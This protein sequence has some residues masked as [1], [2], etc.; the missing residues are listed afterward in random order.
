MALPSSGNI[1]LT[2]IETEFGAP[3]G[4]ALSEFVRG[5]AYVPDTAVN[6]AIPTSTPISMRDFEGASANTL[7]YT[8]E[9][10][11]DPETLVVTAGTEADVV[12]AVTLGEGLAAILVVTRTT[13]AAAVLLYSYSHGTLVKEDDLVLTST[14]DPTG[15]NYDTASIS[16]DKTNDIIFVTAIDAGG[17][18]GLRDQL[19]TWS[20]SYTSTTLTQ[21]DDHLYNHAVGDSTN[22]L[23]C[24]CVGNTGTDSYFIV[25]SM[26][27]NAFSSEYG[28]DSIL[29]SVNQSTG[30]ITQRDRS[31]RDITGATA[32][33]RAAVVAYDEDAWV[34]VCSDTTDA[35]YYDQ[36]R[37]TNT[38]SDD[39]NGSS[40]E[41][42]RSGRGRT[43]SAN[44]S[45]T[46]PTTAS[47]WKR[48][49]ILQEDDTTD[50]QLNVWS[51]ATSGLGTEGWTNAFD[52]V[53][54]A[55]ASFS[56][57]LGLNKDGT[58][59]VA[60]VC[61]IRTG[62][63][64][65]IY[66]TL[67]ELSSEATFAATSTIKSIVT[68]NQGTDDLFQ[69]V[70]TGIGE[71]IFLV[72]AWNNTDSLINVFLV[73]ETEINTTLSNPTSVSASHT[74]STLSVTWTDNASDE[75]NYEVEFTSNKGAT[76]DA[77]TSSPYAANTESANTLALGGGFTY[78]VR[79]RATQTGGA[80]SDWVESADVV[81]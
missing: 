49:Y 53:S 36:S 18:T 41:A 57:S 76:W 39:A 1:S 69:P 28:F 20:I 74:S 71:G 66:F 33:F 37:S 64:D 15:A 65:E 60:V 68:I 75:D 32:S 58:E 48:G 2:D 4:T 16:V 78:R 24:V 11:V 46:L 54:T 80:V 8:L 25:T 63:T 42:T 38:I 22:N 52:D 44:Y 73:E 50:F 35:N 31:T 12:K 17:G 34:I 6:S 43:R 7:T 55:D 14:N 29:Y 45:D 62:N 61:R 23:D 51:V 10:T 56:G 67:R 5:G 19:L 3:S 13:K 21:D 72:A 30:V 59:V 70:V 26:F 79:V 40:Y 9:D 77:F 27:D 47:S 81:T